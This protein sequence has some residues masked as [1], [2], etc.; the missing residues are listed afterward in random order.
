MS[1]NVMKWFEIVFIKPMFVRINMK[2]VTQR[3]TTLL[4]IKIWKIAPLSTLDLPDGYVHTEVL[5]GAQF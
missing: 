2:N 4:M 1:Q 5:T 3:G